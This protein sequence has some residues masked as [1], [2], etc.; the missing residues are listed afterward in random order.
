MG[1]AFGKREAENAILYL[2]RKAL[3][4]AS[5]LIRPFL[6]RVAVVVR[7]EAAP[8]HT[9]ALCFGLLVS[10]T[11]APQ[12]PLRLVLLRFADLHHAGVSRRL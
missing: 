8:L 5:E 7:V 12:P 1:S 2:H 6:R 4:L 3:I 9:P 11:T 10:G